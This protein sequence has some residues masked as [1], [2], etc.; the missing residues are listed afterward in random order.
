MLEQEKF[1]LELIYL[2]HLFV[3]YSTNI[4]RVP[5]MLQALRWVQE[6]HDEHNR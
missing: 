4:Y 2:I 6:Y 1:V 5:I 3:Q